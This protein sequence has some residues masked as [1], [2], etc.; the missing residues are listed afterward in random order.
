MLVDSGQ[1][2]EMVRRFGSPER[3]QLSYELSP[4][5]G[6]VWMYGRIFFICGGLT[7]GNA[8]EQASW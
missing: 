2:G 8:Q 4:R 1:R 5:S 3:F 7:I 6:G